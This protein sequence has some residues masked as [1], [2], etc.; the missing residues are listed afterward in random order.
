MPC[1]TKSCP[2]ESPALRGILNAQPPPGK[3]GIIFESCS[4][5]CHVKAA[6]ELVGL[7][8]TEALFGFVSWLTT[9]AKQIKIGAK[10]DPAPL[11]DVLQEFCRVN[12]LPDTRPDWEAKIRTPVEDVV[13]E[14]AKA[15]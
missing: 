10:G 7:N 8:S 12:K 13:A 3:A 9:R 11:A 6:A 15:G 4:C 2:C 14:P 5:D 1:P